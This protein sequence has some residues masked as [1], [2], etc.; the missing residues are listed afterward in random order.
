MRETREQ[1]DDALCLTRPERIIMENIKLDIAFW[2]YDRT[3]ALADGTVKIDGVESTF[4]TAPIVVEIFRGMIADRQFDVSELGLTYFLRTFTD[5]SSPFVAI[6]IFPNRAFRHSAIFINKAS[7][8]KTPEDMNGKTIGELALYSHDAGVIPKGILMDEFGFKPETCK[9]IIGGLDWPLKPIDFVSHPHP[10][11][12][13]VS[14]IEK[15]KELGA[16]LEAGEIDA[17]ISADIPKCMLENSPKVT[18]LFPDY[19]DVERDYYRRTGIF[20]IMHTVVAPRE[21]VAAHPELPKAI[22]KGFCD[23][24][25]AAEDKYTHGK[26]FNSMELMFPWFNQLMNDDIKVLGD[27]WWPYGIGAN[28]KALDLV[29]RYHYEQGTTE[30]LFTVEDLFLP[31]LLKT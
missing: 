30:K 28:R 12:V 2:N 24:K 21:L 14:Q 23:A 13:Q 26:I 1:L 11:N 19:V 8:I 18:R 29:L 10:A 31:E 6:P 17:L 16:M 25:Q 7:G 4:H 3:R 5:G 27:D 9:W 20:P 22:Y 15:G